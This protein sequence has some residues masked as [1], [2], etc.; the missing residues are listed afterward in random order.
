MNFANLYC[1][2]GGKCCNSTSSLCLEFNTV[3]LPFTPRL[4]F[5]WCQCILVFGM[6]AWPACGKA[7]R[8]YKTGQSFVWSS[9]KS[10][11]NSGSWSWKRKEILLS[12]HADISCSRLA[13]LRTMVGLVMGVMM[14]DASEELQT[15]IRQRA[16]IAFVVKHVTLI[17]VTSVTLFALE[18]S[19]VQGDI[20][21]SPWALPRIKVGVVIMRAQ[22]RDV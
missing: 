22:K 18:R 1:A 3:I 15:S 10:W 21:W 19:Y 8:T 20:R 9:K 14:E 5:F 13:P 4:S 17:I 7:F 16:W 12:V 11:K 2:N 6:P